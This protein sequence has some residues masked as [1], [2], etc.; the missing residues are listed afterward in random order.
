MVLSYAV[1]QP[2]V[3]PTESHPARGQAL[4][5]PRPSFVDS[6][7]A[8]TWALTLEQIPTTAGK[9][10]YV[11]C[12][13]QEGS[14]S[15]CHQGLS[16]IYSGEQADRVLR[17][18]HESIFAEWLNFSLEQQY[19]DLR[20]HLLAS[21]I[22]PAEVKPWLEAQTYERFIPAAAR[23]AERML[24]RTDLETVLEILKHEM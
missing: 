3:A 24:Y 15:Y 11:A 2:L 21:Q 6:D 17:N 16:R 4:A 22:P 19:H 10:F 8:G 18:S 14:E 9:L 12:L 7:A 1:Q 20:V 23:S 5:A 13:R